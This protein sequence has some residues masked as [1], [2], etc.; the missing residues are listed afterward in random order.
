MEGRQKVFGIHLQGKPLADDVSIR[1]LAHMTEG[2]VGSDIE[3]ICREASMLA[4]REV[5]TPGISRDEARAR[6]MGI[7][8]TSVHFVKAIR[9]VK[10][11]TSRAAM[12]LY[13]QASEAFARYSANEEEKVQ[14]LGGETGYQ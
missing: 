8:I 2:Y 12:S 14:D 9:R 1:E 5:V 10:P 3:A 6:V 4:L 7:K 11:T 13:E